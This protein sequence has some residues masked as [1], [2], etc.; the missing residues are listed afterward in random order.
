MKTH[1]DYLGNALQVGDRV[2]FAECRVS[3]SAQR[4]LI[5]GT[6]ERFQPQ[7][8]CVIKTGQTTDYQKSVFD[9]NHTIVE[10]VMKDTFLYPKPKE[11]IKV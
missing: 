4:D 10:R 6:I 5:T 3:N 8:R 11:V 7:G 1:T 9:Y 2:A